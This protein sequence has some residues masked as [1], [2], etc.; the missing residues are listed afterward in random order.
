MFT[1]TPQ[2]SNI[3]WIG[4]QYVTKGTDIGSTPKDIDSVDIDIQIPNRDGVEFRV[5]G[6]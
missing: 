3:P 6:N 4:S 2:S 1:H 5:Y